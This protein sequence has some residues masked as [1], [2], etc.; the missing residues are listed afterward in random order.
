[1]KCYETKIGKRPIEVQIAK[2]VYEVTERLMETKD[3]NRA[4][5]KRLT[6]SGRERAEFVGRTF[7]SAEE[8]KSAVNGQW[9]E[10]LRAEEEL[11]SQLDPHTLPRPRSRRR[12]RVFDEFQ[13]DGVDYDR[14][15]SGQPFW[16]QTKRIVTQGPTSI[17]LV[18]DASSNCRLN[19][20]RILW[21]G[22][23]GCVATRI[24][25]SAGYRVDLWLVSHSHE[26]YYDDC[27]D[28]LAINLKQPG[29]PLNLSSIITATSGWFYRT[30][31]FALKETSVSGRRTT[32][33]L[34]FPNYELT[35]EHIRQF[36]RDDVYSVVKAT[37]LS[38]AVESINQAVET[39]T[40]HQPEGGR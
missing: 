19:W 16:Q 21:K 6:P 30:A 15:R 26:N 9:L 11:Y 3:Q 23:A 10:G 29:T 39:I 13:G 34:G 32:S 28:L 8:W 18:A 1:M 2:S 25:E 35:E 5:H 33:W 17:T 4:V 7:N 38:E 31:I 20:K 12:R 36:A 14:L 22:V 37:S 24:L 40:S 27:D